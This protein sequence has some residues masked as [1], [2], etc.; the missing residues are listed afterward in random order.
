MRTTVKRKD[1]LH[2]SLMLCLLFLYAWHESQ[3]T[4]QPADFTLDIAGNTVCTDNPFKNEYKSITRYFP[5]SAMSF[6][7]D[8]STVTIIFTVY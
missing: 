7:K 6:R 3:P 8:D 1:F 4:G 2:I 5:R